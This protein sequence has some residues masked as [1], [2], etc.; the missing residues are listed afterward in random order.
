MSGDI[1]E[2]L[3]WKWRLFRKGKVFDEE[4]GE[5]KEKQGDMEGSIAKEIAIVGFGSSNL[6]ESQRKK[7][8]GHRQ[9]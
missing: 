3:P 5:E 8:S 4:D 1:G 7:F 9:E 2:G 6:S